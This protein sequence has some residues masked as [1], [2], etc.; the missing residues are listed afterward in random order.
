MKKITG[1][2]KAVD[3][4]HRNHP[5][6]QHPTSIRFRGERYELGESPKEEM[7]ESP[8]EKRAENKTSMGVGESK[9]HPEVDLPYTEEHDKIISRTT[10]RPIEIKFGPTGTGPEGYGGLVPKNPFSS[11]AQAGYLHSHPE[12]L[13]AARLKEFDRATKGKKLPKKVKK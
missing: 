10:G 11:L 5:P 7:M 1:L 4:A 9:P 8:E 6:G 12:I 3:E 2:A 13:G